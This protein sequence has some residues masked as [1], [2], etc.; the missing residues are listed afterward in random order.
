VVQRAARRVAARRGAQPAPDALP[1]RAA[2][3][4]RLR[5]RLGAPR[6]A[7]PA[8]R[9]AALQR[10]RH[11]RP[12]DGSGRQTVPRVAHRRHVAAQGVQPHHGHRRVPVSRI[13]PVGIYL[14]NFYSFLDK[15]RVFN[16]VCFK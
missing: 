2:I 12:A 15:I 4:G 14:E 7:L 8:R 13:L 9:G 16:C 1:A 10:A 5:G 6:P 11:C 3:C